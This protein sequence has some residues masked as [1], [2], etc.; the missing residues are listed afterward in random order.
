MRNRVKGGGGGR[1]VKLHII[2]F[3]RRGPC[4]IVTS[5]DKI[6]LALQSIPFLKIKIGKTFPLNPIKSDSKI[7]YAFRCHTSV[8]GLTLDLI[9]NLN[10]FKKLKFVRLRKK[11]IFRSGM[12]QA[13]C[14]GNRSAPHPSTPTFASSHWLVSLFY[15][16]PSGGSVLTTALPGGAVLRS[17]PPKASWIK[18]RTWHQFVSG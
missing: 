13:G 9:P 2:F 3:Q 12:E 8:L 7:S 18:S 4:V 17:F 10:T 16:S 11:K 5:R 14:H 1:G 15:C 6:W